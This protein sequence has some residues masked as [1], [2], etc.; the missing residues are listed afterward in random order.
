MCKYFHQNTLIYVHKNA[1]QKLEKPKCSLTEGLKKK[2]TAYL[3]S[4][5]IYSNE[6]ET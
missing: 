2:I 4:E 6:K 3:H 5:I 1:M